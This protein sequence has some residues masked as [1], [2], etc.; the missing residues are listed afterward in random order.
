MP[1]YPKQYILDSLALIKDNM[2]DIREFSLR[3]LEKVVKIRAGENDN[4]FDDEGNEVK[5]DWKELATFMLL[6]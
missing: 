3:S 6:S 5:I 1:Q 4:S 2:D